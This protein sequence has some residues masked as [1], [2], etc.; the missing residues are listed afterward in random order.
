MIC[1]V[2]S[3][4]NDDSGHS[5]VLLDNFLIADNTTPTTP[6]LCPWVFHSFYRDRFEN[7]CYRCCLIVHNSCI[8]FSTLFSFIFLLSASKS[9]FNIYLW[10]SAKVSREFLPSSEKREKSFSVSKFLTV[11]STHLYALVD[12]V[13]EELALFCTERCTISFS[14]I[15][16]WKS[17]ITEHCLIWN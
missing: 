8:L 15:K 1:E 5:G 6:L 2:W 3:W 14:Q 12:V 10:Q 17:Q 4:L 7:V 13:K 16:V 11:W 9:G